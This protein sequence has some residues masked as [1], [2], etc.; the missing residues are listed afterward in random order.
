[1]NLDYLHKLHKDTRSYNPEGL[2]LRAYRAISWICRASELV[3]DDPDAGFVFAWISFNAAYAREFESKGALSAR[4][5]FKKF[6]YTLISNDDMGRIDNEIWLHYRG[7][8]K[9]LLDNKYIF[10]PFWQHHN[11]VPGYERWEENFEKAKN[12][13]WHAARDKD[14]PT[15][16]SIVFDRLYVLRN[17]LLHG[18]ATWNSGV[19][20][21]QV[22]C[23]AEFL[24]GLM[25]IIIEVMLKNPSE[26][27]GTPHYPVVD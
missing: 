2:N 1:M 24:L 15:M 18:G 21:G 22:T 27:W 3:S 5:D 11:G 9:D 16:L 12:A 26:D 25:P 4:D 19:N 13:A 8:I 10:H 20:R 14:A 17:Q 6:F 7:A 23:G